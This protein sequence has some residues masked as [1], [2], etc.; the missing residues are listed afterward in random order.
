MERAAVKVSSFAPPPLRLMPVAGMDSL[1]QPRTGTVS[2]AG[3]RNPDATYVINIHNP[4]QETSAESIRREMF[5]LS[6]G[7]LR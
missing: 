7:V 4:V 6:A 1:A 2:R 3:T 5:F